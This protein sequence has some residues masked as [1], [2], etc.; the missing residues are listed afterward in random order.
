MIR[1]FICLAAFIF[2][3]TGMQAQTKTAAKTS[4]YG[5][6]IDPANA[7]PATALLKLMTGKDSMNVKVRGKIIDVCQR[8]GCWMNIELADGKDMMVRFKDYGFFVPKDAAGKTVVM[9]GLAYKTETSV[10][11]LRHYASD[12]GKSKEEIEKINE[13]EKNTSFEASGVLIYNE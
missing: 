10:E 1:S 12:A 4:S 5:S 11:E 13:P 8:K 6:K 3:C 2:F 9:E 7:I